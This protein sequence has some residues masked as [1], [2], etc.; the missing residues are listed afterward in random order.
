MIGWRVLCGVATAVLL[1]T[2]ACADALG[3]EGVGQLR[4]CAQESF[5]SAAG[6]CSRDEGSETLVSSGVYCSIHVVDRGDERFSVLMNFEGERVSSAKG[7]IDRDSGSLWV[8]ARTSNDSRLPAGRWDCTLVIADE[9]RAASFRT[10]GDVKAAP[11]TQVACL[12]SKANGNECPADAQTDLFRR[13]PSVTC[14]SLIV[15][16][17]GERVRIGVFRDAA[18]VASYTTPAAEN[19]VQLAYGT[20]DP[21]VLEIDAAALPDGSYDCRFSAGDTKSWDVSFTVIE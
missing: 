10:G 17:A 9:S 8:G 13:P 4:V 5:D 14:N 2:T 19:N 16:A 7:A 11:V 3:D 1:T 20:V 18:E 12:T 6:D 15:G 21:D